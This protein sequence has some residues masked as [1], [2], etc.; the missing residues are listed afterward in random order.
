MSCEA[1]ETIEYISMDLE[2]CKI[3]YKDARYTFF[4]PIQYAPHRA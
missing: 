1:R 2:R 4:G 3:L